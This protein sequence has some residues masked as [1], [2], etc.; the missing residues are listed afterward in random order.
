MAVPATLAFTLLAVLTCW[1]HYA[2]GTVPYTLEFVLVSGFGLTG[3]LP[4]SS[5]ILAPLLSVYLGTECSENTMR[6]KLIAGHTRT[7]IYLSELLACMA[8]ALALDVLYM[9]LAGALCIPP[10]LKMSG[11]LLRVPFWQLLAWTG[12]ALLARAAYASVLKLLVTVLHHRTAASAGALLLVIGT[13]F[14]CRTAFGQIQ[15]LE[16]SLAAGVPVQNGPARL[17]FWRLLVDVLPTGQYLQVSR[18]DTPNLWRLPLFSLAV[19][20]CTSGAGLLVFQ[21]RNLK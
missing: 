4:V 2:A 11:T 8:T 5:L 1:D 18:L 3:Y 6:N 21:R 9:L 14:L 10:V 7:G 12:A 17:A 20:V 16:Y 13:M 15:F 19:I